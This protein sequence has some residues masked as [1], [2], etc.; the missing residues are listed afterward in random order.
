[1]ADKVWVYIDHFKGEAYPA[2]WEA[3]GAGQKIASELGG[4]VTAV[5][6][7]SNVKGVA[8][9]AAQYGV[10]EVLLADDPTLEDYRPEPYASLLSGLAKER[11]PEV[12]LFPT[13]SR[14]RELAAMTAMDLQAGVLPDV[15][16]LEVQ[17]GIHRRD[18]PGICR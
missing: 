3:V 18:P 6:A 5:V 17:D 16:D 1:M 12:I 7:G 15:I 2:S 4:G 9:E 10:G 8:E 13:T 11:G 14:G